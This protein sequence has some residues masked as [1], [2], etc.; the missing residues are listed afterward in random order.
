VTAGEVIVVGSVNVDLVV[1]IDHLPQ[2]GETVTGGRF[3]R[4][5]GGK[6]GNAAAAAARL[7]ELDAARRLG[8]G[9]RPFSGRFVLIDR[10]WAVWGSTSHALG[11]TAA[12]LGDHAAAGRHFDDALRLQAA[13]AEAWLAHTLADRA[14]LL[15][16]DADADRALA[17]A[18][19][20][21]LDGLAARLEAQPPRPARRA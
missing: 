6:G 7:G 16:G 17:L 3:Q 14:S 12:A 9:L 1:R 20:H 8:A 10:G 5:P 2:A 15:G 21:R 18:R 13:G 4:A 11:V 19:E